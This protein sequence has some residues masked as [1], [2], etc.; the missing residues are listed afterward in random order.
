MDFSEFDR[1]MKYIDTSVRPEYITKARIFK[2]GKLFGYRVDYNG[3]DKLGNEHTLNL[4]RDE[5]AAYVSNGYIQGVRMTSS[6]PSGYDGF[7]LKSLPQIS[8]DIKYNIVAALGVMGNNYVVGFILQNISNAVQN[9]HGERVETGEFFVERADTLKTIEAD[10]NCEQLNLAC[11]LDGKNLYYPYTQAQLPVFDITVQ[12]YSGKYYLREPYIFQAPIGQILSSISHFK[13]SINYNIRYDVAK[14]L[15]YNEQKRFDEYKRNLLELDINSLGNYGNTI[16]EAKFVSVVT[17]QYINRF[18]DKPA[19]PVNIQRTD[20]NIQASS[21]NTTRKVGSTKNIS[22]ASQ[23]GIKG[24][25]DF[26][27][28]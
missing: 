16:E 9:V 3:F 6:G 27:K 5:Y 4:S 1:R 11:N 8:L 18:R 17:D 23:H 24:L 28:R 7:E 25:F 10:T 13:N 21:T 15:N 14:P 26:F 19:V 20:E 22:K 12:D 2:N